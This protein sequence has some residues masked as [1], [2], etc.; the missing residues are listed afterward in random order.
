MMSKS[1][2]IYFGLTVL[3]IVILLFFT[4]AYRVEV[5]FRDQWHLVPMLEKSYTGTLTFQDL[6]SQHYEHRPFFPRIIMILLARLTGWNT[7]Y[8][9]TFNVICAL[10]IFLLLVYQVKKSVANLSKALNAWIIPLIA[11][12]VFSLGQNENFWCGW[13]IAIMLSLLCS[14]TGIILLSNRLDWKKFTV[15]VGMGVVITYSHGTGFAY[16]L[17][18]LLIL[19]M[20]TTNNNR[21]A[22]R[23]RLLTWC[24]VTCLVCFSYFY[25]YKRTVYSDLPLT[26]SLAI[27]SCPFEYVKFVFKFLGSSVSYFSTKLA[28]LFSFFGIVGFA[29]A[30]WFLVKKRRAP[31]QLLIPYIALGIYAVGS[32]FLTG[33]NRAGFCSIMAFSSRYLS[34]SYPFWVS[35]C[36][37]FYLIILISPKKSNSRSISF[38]IVIAIAC[39]AFFSSI[40]GGFEMI[41]KYNF[42]LPIK[43]DFLRSAPADSYILVNNG[44]WGSKKDF[45]ILK[46]HHLSLF[47][48]RSV[49][50]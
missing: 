7:V 28:Y 36:I 41:E 14:V 5:P 37:L 38:V 4:Y 23:A 25:G 10:I 3:S 50:E 43:Q 1:K 9:L 24:F 21:D 17:V 46:K 26:K 47:R 27:F 31:F 33:L 32:A 11:L 2:Y 15:A 18:G 44:A 42:L 8:E 29:Y 19:L 40:K 12:F 45:E 30:V 20:H 16:W 22:A 49:K 34:F 35:V 13:Q 39:S 48:Y 6:F